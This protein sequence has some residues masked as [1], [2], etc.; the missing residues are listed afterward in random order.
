ASRR[1]VR[2]GLVQPSDVREYGVERVVEVNQ[3]VPPGE[4]AQVQ[5]KRTDAFHTAKT[6]E[7]SLRSAFRRM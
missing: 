3:S 5:W 7:C 6:S 1:C 2:S 4:L